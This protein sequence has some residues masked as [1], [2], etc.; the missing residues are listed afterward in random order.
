[1]EFA[2]QGLGCRISG[3]RSL[4]PQMDTISAAPDGPSQ[5]G[6]YPYDL[7]IAEYDS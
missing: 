1:M 4:C 6:V 2:I 3:L 5:G 7:N